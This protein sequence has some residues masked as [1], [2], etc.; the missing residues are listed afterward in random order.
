MNESHTSDKKWELKFC[1]KICGYRQNIVS[2]I[3]TWT[4]TSSHGRVLIIILSTATMR[5][6]PNAG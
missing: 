4:I 2:R 1:E 3:S 6:I 5:A